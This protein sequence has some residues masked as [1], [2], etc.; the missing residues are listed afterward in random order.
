MAAFRSYRRGSFTPALP[1]LTTS[2]LCSIMFGHVGRRYL[3]LLSILFLISDLAHLYFS[4]Y[5]IFPSFN[6][7]FNHV[8]SCHPLVSLIV[9]T[10]FENYWLSLLLP[11]LLASASPPSM[12]VCFPGPP[13]SPQRHKALPPAPTRSRGAARSI[14]L[15]VFSSS[16]NS[17]S[18]PIHFPPVDRFLFTP[19]QRRCFYLQRALRLAPSRDSSSP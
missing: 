2:S 5:L 16:I 18:P 9:N 13:L 1:P 15:A 10:V 11:V 14:M 19:L 12:F 8:R 4:F 6:P 3:L 17:P 7:S